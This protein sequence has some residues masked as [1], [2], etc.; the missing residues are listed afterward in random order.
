[1]RGGVRGRPG[2][3]AG[4]RGTDLV[5]ARARRGGSGGSGGILS[6][7]VQVRVTANLRVATERDGVIEGRTDRT[8]SGGTGCVLA[9]GFEATV[10][11]NR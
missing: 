8:A 3:L 6:M 4:A 7:S 2:Q 10:S 5:V 1:M 9:G 11:T